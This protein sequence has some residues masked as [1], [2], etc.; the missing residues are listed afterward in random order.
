MPIEEIPIIAESPVDVTTPIGPVASGQPEDF[1]IVQSSPVITPAR[2]AWPWAV[3]G[4]LA[5]L[6]L[7]GSGNWARKRWS[8]RTVRAAA[9]ADAGQQLTPDTSDALIEAKFAIEPHADRGVQEIADPE[10]LQ[11][12]E[13]RTG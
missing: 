12:S 3:A 2:R 1:V 7:A 8:L 6:M 11:V 13:Q 5:G 10:S 4:T 9:H